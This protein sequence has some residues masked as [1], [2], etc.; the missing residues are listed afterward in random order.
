MC[1]Y[2][3]NGTPNAPNVMTSGYGGLRDR[4]LRR[5]H[6]TARMFDGDREAANRSAGAKRHRLRICPEHA[7]RDG[8]RRVGRSG[9]GPQLVRL[10]RRET[11]EMVTAEIAGAVGQQ[12]DPCERDAGLAGKADLQCAV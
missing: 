11:I 7:R 8:D 5:L 1:T 4:S 3:P 9:H 2:T 6:D 10:V 12:H